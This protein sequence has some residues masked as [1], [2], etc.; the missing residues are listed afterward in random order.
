MRLCTHVCTHTIDGLTTSTRRALDRFLRT[1]LPPA[2]VAAGGDG[3]PELVGGAR[4]PEH[5]LLVE[6]KLPLR[7]LQQRP[8]A[9]LR[10]RAHVHHHPLRLLAP[11]H[12]HRHAAR[13]HAPRGGG[14][15]DQPFPHLVPAAAAVAAS[16]P[17]AL[18]LPDHG[19]APPAWGM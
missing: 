12:Q 15:V 2:P 17:G 7:R 10:Q 1:L 18:P 16:S 3:S 4:D 5:A 11:A 13:R 8:H 14:G 9:G 19:A 6:P